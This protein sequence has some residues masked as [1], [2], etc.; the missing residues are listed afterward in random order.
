MSNYTIQIQRIKEK[1]A[2]AK[3]ADR[4]FKVF[5]ASKH[6]YRLGRTVTQKEVSD[7][8]ERYI[9]ELPECYKAFIMEFCGSG[10]LS[11]NKRFLHT[12]PSPYYGLHSF[13]LYMKPNHRTFDDK[14]SEILAEEPCMYPN[15]SDKEWKGYFDTL[16]KN[17]VWQELD[18]KIE[19]T[20]EDYYELSGLLPLGERGCHFSIALVMVGQ[21]RGRVVYLDDSN[22][23]K[24]FF[25]YEDN[26]LDWYE[27]WL[28]EITDGTLLKKISMALQIQCKGVK[29]S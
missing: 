16:A 8:E 15:M 6:E 25:T 11:R 12:I 4:E 17:P 5:G 22:Y 24:P 18:K 19:E 14:L 10:V 21:Y 28:D 23:D 7:F 9:V 27:R 26:F 13:E 20:D 1:F 2:Q 3:E 29:K